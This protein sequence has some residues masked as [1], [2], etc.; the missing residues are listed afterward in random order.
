MEEA[1]LKVQK[2]AKVLYILVKIARIALTISCSVVFVFAIIS[3]IVKGKLL[4]QI[5]ELLD[6]EGALDTI[7]R[8][9]I[10]NN[11]DKEFILILGTIFHLLSRAVTII[12]L[13]IFGRMLKSI[14]SGEQP[15]TD[16]NSKKLYYMAISFVVFVFINPFVAVVMIIAGLFLAS[17]IS[18]GAYLNKKAEETNHIQESMIVSFAEV[19]ENKS[20]Q[21]G[22]HVKRVAEYSKVIAKELG[23]S[24]EK[25]EQLKMASM[26]HDIGK[27]LVPSEILEKPA[28][29]TD[30]EFMEIKKHPVYGVKLLKD[31]DGEVL[32]LAKEIAH[33]HHERVDGHG[34]PDG[35]D[36][37]TISIESK[38]VAVADVYDALTSKRSYKEA[39]DEKKAY[40]EIIN[41]SGKQFDENVVEAFKKSYDKI[42]EI[43]LKFVD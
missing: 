27:L 25:A 12:Y 35:L 31:V 9:E 2:S 30:D 16:K 10:L 40:E 29:L 42:N 18:Y 6:S 8:I 22:K 20:E 36:V 19:V 15:F 24:E 23:F 4:D 26:M 7:E 32:S 14:A 11:I 34:Y 38:I 33:E 41:G 39:W 17:L 28:R 1:R 13:V 37:S 3:L 43:R 21:T 5:I